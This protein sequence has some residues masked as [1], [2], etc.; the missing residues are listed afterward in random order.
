MKVFEM[1]EFQNWEKMQELS[2][3]IALE[4]AN[5][6]NSRIKTLKDQIRILKLS[7]FN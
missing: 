3:E 5:D 6:D 1:M 2:K 7:I 4:H